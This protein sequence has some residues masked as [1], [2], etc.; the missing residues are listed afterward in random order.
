MVADRNELRKVKQMIEK[1]EFAELLADEEV[2]I[3]SDFDEQ[4]FA[5]AAA[6]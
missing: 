3:L 1:L 6:V 4:K 5:D 2:I